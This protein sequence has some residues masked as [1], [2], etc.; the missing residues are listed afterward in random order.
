MFLVG[1]DME[2][3]FLN[4]LWKSSYNNVIYFSFRETIK[5]LKNE[6]FWLKME[7]IELAFKREDNIKV[8]FLQQKYLYFYYD[9]YID[10]SIFCQH[11]ITCDI[12]SQD[13]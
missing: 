11:W 2:N 1:S 12:Y 4:F 6:N 7:N 10:C 5:Q 9:F 3:Y 13:D 8:S